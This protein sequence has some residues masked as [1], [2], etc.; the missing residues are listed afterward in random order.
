[1]NLENIN[2]KT[3]NTWA[4]KG[5][6]EGMERGHAPAVEKMFEL[7]HHNTPVIDG[8]FKV[9]DLGCGNGWV[10]RKFL[11]NENCNYALGIDGAPA[12]IDKA[13]KFDSAGNYIN[14]DIE[15]WNCSEK[16]DIIFSM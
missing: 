16:F 8:T 11:K 7:I 14:A 10:V 9:L 6:D 4:I 15:I 13:K 12:M 5:K 2:I 1:M 3:F